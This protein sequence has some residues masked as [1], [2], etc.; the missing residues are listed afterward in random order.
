MAKD[1]QEE[2]PKKRQC[3]F[4]KEHCIEDGCSIYMKI[5]STQ[6]GVGRVVGTC[7]L[8]AVVLV[9]STLGQQQK[10]QRMDL[11]DLRR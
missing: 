3:P 10:T 6:F 8:V 1:K 9:L 11:S 7:A 5:Q 4:L 2:Q